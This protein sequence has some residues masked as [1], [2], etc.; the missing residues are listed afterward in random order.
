MPAAQGKRIVVFV[1]GGTTRS[2]VRVAH[3]L[4]ERLGR[5]VLLG[6]TSLDSP[7]TF[8]QHLQACSSC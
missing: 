1:V 3:R 6:S 7:T 8:L 5:E 4:S 2:E